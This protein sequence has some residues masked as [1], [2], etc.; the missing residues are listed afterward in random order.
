MTP[1]PQR[2]SLADA[3]SGVCCHAKHKSTCR[4]EVTLTAANQ[5]EISCVHVDQ[6]CGKLRFS[7]HYSCG[8]AFAH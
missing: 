1:V 4:A 5:S 3:A 2:L 6:K 8:I 7:I